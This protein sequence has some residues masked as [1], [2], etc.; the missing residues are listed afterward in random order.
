[1]GDSVATTLDS[2]NICQPSLEVEDV[3]YY[4]RAFHFL[5]QLGDHIPVCTPLFNQGRDLETV[6]NSICLYYKG[7]GTASD[8]ICFF[9]KGSDA[10]SDLVFLL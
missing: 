10:V 2:D 5:N 9:Y 8:L 4:D 1:M 7:S 3:S 6:S